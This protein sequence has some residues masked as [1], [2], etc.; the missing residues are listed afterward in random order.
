MS[1]PGSAFHFIGWPGVRWPLAG[2]IV[3]CAMLGA[4]TSGGQGAVADLEYVVLTP[5]VLSVAYDGGPADADSYVNSLS[6]NGRFVV[7]ESAAA[8]LVADDRNGYSDVF[9]RDRVIGTTELVSVGTIGQQGTG[10]SSG[11]SVSD[12]GRWVAFESMAANLFGGDVEGVTSRVY[13]RDRVAGTTV[14]IGPTG[15]GM[16]AGQPK[17]SGDGR[18]VAYTLWL[19]DEVRP[20]AGPREVVV[21]YEVASGQTLLVS[22]PPAGGEFVANASTA[23]ISADGGLILF[24]AFVQRPGAEDG[25]LDSQAFLRDVEAGTTVLVSAAAG[26]EQANSPV[27]PTDLSADGRFAVFWTQASN[28]PGSNGR[29]HVYVR[30]LQVGT[31]SRVTADYGGFGGDISDDGRWVVFERSFLNAGPASDE[32]IPRTVFELRDRSSGKLYRVAARGQTEDVRGLGGMR[33]TGNGHELIGQMP[34]LAVAPFTTSRSDIVVLRAP[35]APALAYRAAVAGASREVAPIE[36][37][38][39]V[40][41]RKSPS[42]HVVGIDFR[43]A[44]LDGPS[45]IRWLRLEV[46]RAQGP[47]ILPIPWAEDRAFFEVGT[48]LIEQASYHAVACFLTGFEPED[49]VYCQDYQVRLE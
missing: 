44:A 20:E 14:L 32:E 43:H 39:L 25:F 7:F 36:L 30:D 16:G 35:A 11:G 47:M 18:Y 22:I 6:S 10:H 23:A 45:P 42:T 40:E 49:V 24:S 28:L 15:A 37:G 13:L 21:R 29:D 38:K 4:G 33:I 1:E 27:Y 9:L 19:P 46:Y 8:T 34:R 26:G 3:A 41:A 17:V 12:D 2:T 48:K 5:N 31:T